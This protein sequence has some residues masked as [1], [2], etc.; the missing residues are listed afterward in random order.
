MFCVIFTGK[1]N[2]VY[3]VEADTQRFK[4]YSTGKNVPFNFALKM[5]L[6]A[7]WS[8]DPTASIPKDRVSWEKNNSWIEV[9][10]SKSDEVGLIAELDYKKKVVTFK[11][12]P[13]KKLVKKTDQIDLKHFPSLASDPQ[14]SKPT[15]PIIKHTVVKA[16]PKPIPLWK[17]ETGSLHDL[18]KKWA[19]KEQY[20]ILWNS[21]TDFKIQATAEI[22]G[23]FLDAVTKLVRT[24]HK[25]GAPI[26]AKIY[27]GNKVVEVVGE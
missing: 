4:I 18:L 3:V 14:K 6:P 5:I 27:T 15:L 8:Y 11:K 17:V 26:R 20:T 23:S 1:A 13:V 21:K 12:K 7:D 19:K 22:K 2:A 16:K 25:G 24:M 10:R 9:L